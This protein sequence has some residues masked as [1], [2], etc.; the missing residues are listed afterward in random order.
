MQSSGD[1]G[2][3]PEC[4]KCGK[5]CWNWKENKPEDKCEYLAEDMRTCKIH[6]KLGVLRPECVNFPK[7]HHS[8]DLPSECPFKLR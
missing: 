4:N 6:D 2:L 1:L 8:P 3:S 5:C 7:P